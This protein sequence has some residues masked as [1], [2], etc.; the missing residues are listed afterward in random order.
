MREACQEFTART[1]AAIGDRAAA[2]PTRALPSALDAG[3]LRRAAFDKV[4]MRPGHTLT[5]RADVL[6]LPHAGY[7]TREA[8]RRLLYRSNEH[9]ARDRL[10]FGG[11]EWP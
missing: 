11:N 4:P 2:E 7:K 3:G 5:G 10:A 9:A 6:L 8:F 1:V